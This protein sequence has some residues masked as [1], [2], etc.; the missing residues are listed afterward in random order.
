[1]HRRARRS[2]CIRRRRHRPRR[3]RRHR[4]PVAAGWPASARPSRPRPSPRCA[5]SSGSCGARPTAARSKAPG[6]ASPPTRACSATARRSSFSGDRVR[7]SDRPRSGPPAV[8]CDPMNTGMLIEMA[9]DGLGDRIA[10]RLPQAGSPT[11]GCSTGPAGWRPWWRTPG[12]E[13]LVFVDQNSARS[14]L[15]LF[16][17]A[18]PACRSC[19]STTAWPT[20]SCAPSWPAP[21]PAVAVVDDDAVGRVGRHGRASRA[22]DRRALDA[23]LAAATSRA[24]SRRSST[25]TT[26]PCCSSPAAPPASRR[27]RCCATGTS[28]PT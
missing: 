14:R 9:A 20:S 27:R 5:S 17:A 2:S 15:L 25:P 28:R 8:P 7:R 21:R 23:R 18:W 13:R 1:M 4:Q 19:R 22:V 6:S 26:S 3:R 12:A 11:P 24:P 10:R 16:G